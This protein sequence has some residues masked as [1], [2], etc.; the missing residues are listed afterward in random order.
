MEKKLK[1]IRYARFTPEMHKDLIVLAGAEN[2]SV[3]ESDLD[4]YAI[5]E[6]GAAVPHRPEVVIKP[7]DTSMVSKIMAYA[8]KHDIP[9]TPRG[10]GT[11]VSGGSIPLYGGILLS[12]EKMDHIMKIDPD[13]F[14]AVVEPGVIVDN[15]NLELSKANLY[16]PVHISART[17]TIGGNA[18]TNAGGMNAVKYGVTRQQILGIEAVMADGA[19]IESGGEYV[20]CSTGY[21]LTQLILGSEGTLAVITK[22]IIKVLP[23]PQATEILFVPFSD[24]QKAIDTVPVLLRMKNIPMGLEFFERD[25]IEVAEKY[26]KYEVPGHGQEAFLMILMEG[27]SSDDI[28][29]YFG[30]IEQI[31]RDRGAVDFFAPG[32]ALAKRKLIEFREKIGESMAQF[33]KPDSV[34]TVVPRNNIAKYVKKIKEIAAEFGVKVYLTGHA[35]DG[36]VHFSPVV[37]GKKTTEIGDIKSRFLERIYRECVALGG[38]ISGEHGLGSEK[39]KYLSIGVSSETLGV[40]SAIKDAF[41]PKHIL[42]PGKIFSD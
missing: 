39:K 35:G 28:M 22:L 12:F 2:I 33:G 26:L 38:N 13:N 23:L 3:K 24:L 19:V 9:V 4:N 34:D 32:D 21:N 31:C 40:M 30:Q 18:S 1:K 16:Y 25:T 42:N 5:D 14:T 8:S 10:G 41:D 6:A 7:V 20:K 37:P 29:Q 17:A 36:N 15:L 27:D 11:G